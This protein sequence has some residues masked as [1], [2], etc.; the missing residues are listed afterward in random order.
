MEF[1]ILFITLLIIINL[2]LLITEYF[3]LLFITD[4]ILI[5]LAFIYNTYHYDYN[6]DPHEGFI[7]RR[8]NRH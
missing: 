7:R 1:K 6:K 8:R 2:I 5:L 4:F 3:I